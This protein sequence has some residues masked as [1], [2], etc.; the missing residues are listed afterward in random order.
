MNRTLQSGFFCAF[1]T[2]K[3]KNT[4]LFL[5][6]TSSESYLR[7]IACTFNKVCQ[8]SV[9]ANLLMAN[10]LMNEIYIFIKYSY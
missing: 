6:P 4:L 10:L 8:N 2:T 9:P 3:S 7:Q 1:P 5:L